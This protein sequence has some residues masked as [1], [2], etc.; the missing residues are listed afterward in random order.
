MLRRPLAA[1]AALVLPAVLA[2]AASAERFVA[3]DAQNRLYTLDSDAPGTWKRAALTGLASGERIV[4]LDVRP[5]NRQLI[6]VTN[7]SRL[8][9]ISRAKRSAT[10]IGAAPFTPALSGA[11]FG[12]DFNPTVDRIRLVSSAG[13]DLRLHPDTGAVAATDKPLAYK[14]GDAGAGAAPA[15]LGSAYTNSVRGATTTALYGI[16][17]GRDTLV[18]QAPP[19]DG[20]L[21]TVGPLGVNLAGPLG[22]DISARDGV[23][24]VL[25]RRAGAPRSRLY[26]VDLT[27][28]AAKQLGAI[29][30]APALVALAALSAPRAG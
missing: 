29:S 25:A 24:Y 12:F 19:N 18:L 22:F 3:V 4:G 1:L 26:S 23:A 6:G 11:S 15:V 13:Q 17:S 9:A 30:R 20:V 16:D 8:V 10:A 2:P 21:S 27:T 5:L 7:R 14:A 28:G